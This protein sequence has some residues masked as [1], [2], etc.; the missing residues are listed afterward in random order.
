MSQGR[1]LPLV[2]PAL[3]LY[4]IAEVVT[5]AT[6][7]D[8]TAIALCALALG[9][10]L[11]PA[12]FLRQKDALTGARRVTLLGAACG[13]VLVR[14]SEPSIGSLYLDFASAISFAAIGVTIA[15]L[16]VATPDRWEALARRRGPAMLLGVGAIVSASLAALAAAPAFELR[17]F[18]VIVPPLYWIA[19][20]IF[21]VVALGLALGARLARRRIGS[22]PEALAAGMWAQLGLWAGLAAGLLAMVLALTGTAI[23]SAPLRGLVAVGCAGLLAGHVGMIGAWQRKH[24]G[25]STRVVLAGA[26]AVAAVATLCAELAWLVPDDAFAVG[27][28]IALVVVVAALVH[29][30][31][32]AL[33]HR[34][35]APFGG[36]LL[37]AI[38]EAIEAAADATTLHELGAAVLPP[39]RRRSGALDAEPLLWTI[40]P[41]RTIRIDAAGV[42]HV[43][44][45]APSPAIVA[46]VSERPGEVVVSAPL[47]ATV[48]RRPDLRHLVDA[49]ERHDALCVV[50]LSVRMD[51]EGVL[52]VPRGKRRGAVSL[53]EI[54]R[55]EQLGRQ[56]AARV[57]LLSAE[58]RSRRRTRDAIL[59]REKIED[60][61][62]ARQDELEAVRAEARMLKSGGAAERYSQPPIAYSGSMRAVVKRATDVSPVDAPALLIGEEG[63]ELD[64]IAHLL[65]SAGGR[66]EGP[67]VIAD[68]TSV[69]P[70]RAEAALFGEGEDARRGWLR[71]AEGGTCL[72]MEVPALS[73]SAQAKLADAI[74]TR[75]CHPADGAAAYSVDARVV[76]TSR[77]DL[78]ELA[79]IGAF[80]VE[81]YRRF[82]PLV[83]R[84][85]PLRERRED[86][87]SLV[88][89][90]LDRTCRTAGRPVLGIDPDAL[91][92]LVAHDW[93][94]NQ[95]E[96]ASVIDRAVAKAAGP[97]VRLTDLP[98]LAKAEAE[99]IVDPWT[100]TYAELEARILLHAMEQAKGNKSEAARLLGLKR[101]TFLDKLKRHDLAL[102]AEDKK[103]GTAA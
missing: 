24:A 65:H 7:M 77:I 28:V 81:L 30:A 52:V 48:V 61:L 8:A 92:M 10:S 49:L 9:L 19:A 31:I 25:R 97:T 50:P 89:L 69:R 51:L 64:A 37:L 26:L 36:Q 75:R 53:E 99:V 1:I 44:D 27:V 55:L 5:S 71:L 35:L 32:G 47:I 33:L 78:A 62:E 66:R 2:G 79:A 83:L 87:P 3:V 98:P 41:P 13:V 76:A 42:A 40:D 91:A 102:A 34:W 70:E 57:A 85:P 54:D 84:V 74:A 4:S 29:R 14:F 22:T 6:P 11:F 39:L 43:E 45:I 80:D 94:G 86:V 63:T 18:T 93:P 23:G 15:S 60:L 46:R 95:R 72:L 82:E 96:L 90:A 58:E 12:L 73:L 68:C 101:T 20:P 21:T 67:F 100:G 16:A 103:Q 38:D 59:E 56:L 17:G 88:L